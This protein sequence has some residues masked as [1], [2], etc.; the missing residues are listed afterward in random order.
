MMVHNVVVSGA[1]FDHPEMRGVG[2]PANP[3]TRP[4][5]IVGNGPFMLKEWKINSHILVERNPT[6]WD[7]KSV[8]LNSIYFDPEENYDTE[9]RMFRSGQLHIDRIRR[10]RPKSPFTARTSPNLLADYP[11]LGTYY[12]RFNVTK[13]PLNDKRVRQALAMSI[14]RR[15]ICETVTR[16]GEHARLSV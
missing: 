7:A 3:W 4:E 13:P 6:F 10:L 14:D 5:R 16:G 15:A 12:Y 9:E 2:R 11:M 8:R 1:D